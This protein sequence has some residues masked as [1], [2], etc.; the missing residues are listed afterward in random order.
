MIPKIQI[1]IEFE[2]YD[3]YN[4]ATPVHGRHAKGGGGGS[5]TTNTQDT[6][7]NARLATI[8]ESELGMAQEYFDFWKENEAPVTAQ[9]LEANASLIPG[10]TAL[11]SA[12]IG[13][14]STLLP[15]HTALAEKQI[16]AQSQLLDLKMPVANE[17]YNQVRKGIDVNDAMG[18]ATADVEQG[19]AG[20]AG[21]WRREAGRMGLD[22]TSGAYASQRG[23]TL[24]EKAK[25]LAGAKTGARRYAEDTNF[26]RL[27]TA[28]GGG[29]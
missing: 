29:V 16:G 10:Q 24:R 17:Y 25:S 5:T 7:Y 1:G 19:Y 23:A 8:Q 13:A 20:A 18:R 27:S 26:K 3:P 12:K 21:A 15:Q 22:P 11:E 4:P 6:A 28:M 14:E 2:R 9:M